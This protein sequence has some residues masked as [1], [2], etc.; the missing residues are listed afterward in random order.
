MNAIILAAGAGKR[1]AAS[2][3]SKPK[4]LL[5]VGSITLLDNILLSL[6]EAGVT[7]ATIVVGYR[8]DLVRA[9]AER[10]GLD[11]QF[12]VN[13][14]YADTN[15]IYSLHLAREAMSE[16]FIYFNADV[17]FDRRIV[18][19]LLAVQGSALAVQT[20]RCA[21]E[22]VKVIADGDGRIRRIGKELDPKLCLGEFIGV[23]KFCL[24]LMG[25][26][27]DALAYYNDQTRQ[28]KLFFEAAVDRICDRHRI[29]A[30]DI[31]PYPAIE[32]DT[33]DDL[34]RAQELARTMGL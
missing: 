25:D 21:Q 13:D 1:L 28:R 20:G 10:G 7:R 31:A 14:D 18:A 24:P 17:L 12:I 22:E 33:S 16:D 19:R 32:I 4:C 11:L 9:E 26:F 15:T 23:G 3:W 27:R 6:V 34:A 8:Q 5:P 29:A 2:G 30:V